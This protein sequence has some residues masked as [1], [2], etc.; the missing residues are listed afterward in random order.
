MII[1]TENVLN[2]SNY[3]FNCEIVIVRVI[4]VSSVSKQES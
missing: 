2:V 4:T 1:R 3:I